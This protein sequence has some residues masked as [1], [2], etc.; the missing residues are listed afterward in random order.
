MQLSF[1]NRVAL[2]TGAGR[3]IGKA[4]AEL[5][6]AEGA[7]VICVSKN[8]A[9]CSAVAAGIVAAG[10]NAK[11]MAVD[12]SDRVAVAAACEKL[13]AEYEA[14]DI[15]VN[16]AGITRDNLM[17][18]MKDEEW[19]DVLQTNLSSAFYWVK[20]LLKGMTRKRWGRIIN[21]ASVSGVL[22]NPGQANYAAA[23][24]GLIGFTKTL[25]RELSSRN[26]TSNAIAPGFISSDMTALLSEP[27]QEMI[28][29]TIPLKRMGEPGDIAR[30]TAY[31][32]S[33][34]GGYITGQ[35]FSIDGGMAM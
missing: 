29:Q 17:L 18:R 16:N 33:E 26:I 30:M 11:A 15:L 24:A 25:A 21:M 23:K 5:L 32:A 7:T 20:G 2:V 31:L 4:I 12:V 1:N 6:A 34:E 22:G 13:L 19:D 3:G 28:L 10:G 35:V 9:N 8:E 27:I 14:I